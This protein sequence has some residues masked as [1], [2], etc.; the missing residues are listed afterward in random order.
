MPSEKSPERKKAET[1]IR[2]GLKTA[3]IAKKLN[4][5]ERTIRRWKNAL[6]DASGENEA[7][8]KNRTTAVRKKEGGQPG[9]VNAVGDGA[10]LRN[11]NAEVHGLYAK[12][13]PKETL[14]IMDTLTEVSPLDAL[15]KQIL[16][17]Q[18]VILRSQKIFEM[19]RGEK[20]EEIAS[21]GEAGTS[22]L[23]QEPWDKEAQYLAAFSRAQGTLQSMIK[24]YM[25]MEG[26]SRQ[27]AAADS[28]DWKSAILEIA[29]RR[30]EREEEQ[31]EVGSEI[32]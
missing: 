5:S 17:Q 31:V 1:L 26:K 25:E 21:E 27:E 16:N 3:E 13:L 29:A 23:I 19:H 28:K 8:K 2:K 11:K 22:Y 4:V 18:A 30:Q 32:Q 9:N 10:P 6:S 20:T 15:W 7:D 14:E 24:T 12:Y